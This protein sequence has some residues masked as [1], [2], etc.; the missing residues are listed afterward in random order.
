MIDVASPSLMSP[1]ATSSLL[2]AL[3]IDAILIPL[4]SYSGLRR[5]CEADVTSSAMARNASAA[6]KNRVKKISMEDKDEKEQVV[7]SRVD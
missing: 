5:I 6:L 3:S 7:G 4:D 2:D 1:L